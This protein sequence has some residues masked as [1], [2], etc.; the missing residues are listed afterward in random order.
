MIQVEKKV[1]I[2]ISEDDVQTLKNICHCA[3]TYLDNRH[4]LYKGSFWR[5]GEVGVGEWSGA[6]LSPIGRLIDVI[7]D[8]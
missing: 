1:T 5:R 7:F 6:E 2:T 4:D 8:A 3:R